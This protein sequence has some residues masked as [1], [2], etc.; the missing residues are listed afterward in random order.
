MVTVASIYLRFYI[1][2][3]VGVG[4]F[5]PPPTP[6]KIPS[7]SDPTA[8]TFSALNSNGSSVH[9]HNKQYSQHNKIKNTSFLIPSDSSTSKQLVQW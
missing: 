2:F 1:E 9:M 5:L 4:T 7:D 3:G 8:L 6:P